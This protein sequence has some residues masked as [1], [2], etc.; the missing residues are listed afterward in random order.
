MTF[1]FHMLIRI[2]NVAQ[3]NMHSNVRWS[4]RLLATGVTETDL[5]D[6]VRGP[7]HAWDSADVAAW[8]SGNTLP[9]KPIEA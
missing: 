4:L 3:E 2:Q 1:V 6:M 9:H 5:G 7:V 8:L